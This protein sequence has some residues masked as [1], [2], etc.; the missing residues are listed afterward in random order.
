MFDEY[1]ENDLYYTHCL[2]SKA[3][4][5]RPKEIW[6][7]VQYKINGGVF[8]L[9]INPTSI[10]FLDFWIKNMDRPTW[11]EWVDFELRNQ[12]L[13]NGNTN[14]NWWVDQ[15]FLNC[16]DIHSVPIKRN[17]RKVDV[18]YHYNYFTSKWGYF[19]VELNMGNKIG[20]Q[21]IKIIHFKGDFK[22]VYN[23]N[24]RIIYN[25]KNIL[26]KKDLTTIFSRELI[27]KKFLSR[28]EKRFDIA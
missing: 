9:T 3:E 26:N 11:K 10:E 8:G 17:L 28:G 15:E 23:I 1:P 22:E 21:S 20:N 13:I 24:N 2:M 4:S 16:V 27:Y 7:S 25:M 14:L 6:Q 19:D 18:G 12:H 5:K